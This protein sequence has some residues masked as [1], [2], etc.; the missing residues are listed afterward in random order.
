MTYFT[1][2]DLSDVATKS[3]LA[4]GLAQKAN[5][6]TVGGIATSLNSKASQSAL[7]AAVSSIPAPANAMPPAVSDSGA[8]GAQARYAREDHTH[9][10]KVRKG[11]ASVA[12]ATYPWTYPTPF[13]AGVSPIVIGMAQSASGTDLFNVQLDGTPTNTGC[14]FRIN[15]V[16][17]GLLGLLLGALSINPT[18]ASITLHMLALE[19]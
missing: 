4:L 6:S 13:A 7:D 1:E 10:S 11:K 19:P 8:E 2:Q 16:S 17:P 3:E 14:T 9:A 18:P 15:R 5:A 12:A